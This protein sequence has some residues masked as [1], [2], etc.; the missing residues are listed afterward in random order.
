MWS[1]GH[2]L[3]DHTN[4]ELE[5][6]ALSAYLKD[7][8]LTAISVTLW[9]LRVIARNFMLLVSEPE[10]ANLTAGLVASIPDIR[11]FLKNW[12]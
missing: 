2:K 7:T 12:D 3:W 11:K 10:S 6:A 5:K 4:T 1:E 8:M 9:H